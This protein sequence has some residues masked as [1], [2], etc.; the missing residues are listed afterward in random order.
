M[1]KNNDE[2]IFEFLKSINF[3]QIHDISLIKIA[4]THSS[5]VKENEE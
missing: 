1:L 3:S 5:Y 2:R 4:L